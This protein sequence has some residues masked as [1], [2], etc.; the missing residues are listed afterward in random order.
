M[1]ISMISAIAENR[2]IGNKNSLPWHLP[3]DF[4]Y[5]KAQTL[6]KP[7][8][9]GLKTFESI[10]SKP[11]PNRKNIILNNNPNYKIPENCFLARSIEEA[12][13]MTKNEDEV[14]I[15]GG[16]S[17]YRQFLP[18]ADRLYLT[19]IHQNFEGDTLFPEFN[20][21]EWKEISREDHEPDEKNKYSYSFVV[22]E[23]K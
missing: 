16:A 13:E 6:N 4:K 20:I 22:L 10:G 7:I 17:V 23:R 11:L 12:L 9:M 8:V 2:V 5:F 1:I 3:A 15:C 14:M 19:Y 18:L 21:N